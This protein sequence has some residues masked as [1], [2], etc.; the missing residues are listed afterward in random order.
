MLTTYDTYYVLLYARKYCVRGLFRTEYD[1]TRCLIVG[2]IPQ[3][4]MDTNP[5]NLSPE[6]N[7]R[8]S[9]SIS[10]SSRSSR[11]PSSS[12]CCSAYYF[13]NSYHHRSTLALVLCCNEVNRP[14]KGEGACCTLRIGAGWSCHFV[15]FCRPRRETVP[16]PKR[17]H[18]GAAPIIYNM[19]QGQKN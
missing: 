19:F 15:S 17:C 16:P 1:K 9:S 10:S 14:S 18:S 7:A 5:A 13:Q 11:T 3:L 12:L 4:R 8:S 6:D 2:S